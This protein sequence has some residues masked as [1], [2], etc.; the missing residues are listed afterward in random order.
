MVHVPP[1]LDA[2]PGQ[3]CPANAGCMVSQHKHA[4][5]CSWAEL[6]GACMLNSSM[7]VSLGTLGCI[8]AGPYLQ[9]EYALT[10]DKRLRG[11]LRDPS[12]IEAQITALQVGR[13]GASAV[14]PIA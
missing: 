2:G 12:A 8:L 7:P 10:E 4:S 9:V 13:A 5:T 11:N 6:P 3:V 1:L 14:P